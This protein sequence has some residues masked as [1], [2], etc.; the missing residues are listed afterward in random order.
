MDKVQIIV[1]GNNTENKTDNNILEENKKD[2]NIV[3]E[4]IK[5]N[6]I[7]EESNKDKNEGKENKIENNKPNKPKENRIEKIRKE[8]NE[9]NRKNNI[10]LKKQL[11]EISSQIEEIFSQQEMKKNNKLQNSMDKVDIKEFTNF[12]SKIDRYKRKI[13]SKQKEINNNLDFENIIKNENEYKSITSKL[14][15][16]KKEN[17]YLTKI[18]EQLKQEY[19]EINGGE[20]LKGKAV[21]M[22]QKLTFLIAEIKIMNGNSKLL[23]KQLKAQDYEINELNQYIQKVNNNIEYAK[24][25]QMQENKDNNSDEDLVKKISELKDLIKK[26]EIEKG[27]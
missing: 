27:K 1:K 25:E 15:N 23:K 6:N 12:K 11:K 10:A 9:E 22:D 20:Q 19:D 7:V 2:S 4:N 21:Q 14:L 24:N 18:Y 3:K 16:L 8:N 26:T 5:D 13:E 17:E